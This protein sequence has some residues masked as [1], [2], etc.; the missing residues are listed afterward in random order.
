M[1]SGRPV[2]GVQAPGHLRIPQS[3]DPSCA[4]HATRPLVRRCFSRASGAP[5]DGRLGPEVRGMEGEGGREDGMRDGSPRFASRVEAALANK[6]VNPTRQD[7]ALESSRSRARGL[8]PH[9][10]AGHSVRLHVP[11][12]GR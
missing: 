1:K 11:C 6:G 4:R 12:C 5:R 7:R 8:R 9:R 2:L 3:T 10:S